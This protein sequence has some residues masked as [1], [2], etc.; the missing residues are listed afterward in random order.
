ML[1]RVSRATTDDLSLVALGRLVLPVGCLV[2][3]RRAIAANRKIEL[4]TVVIVSVRDECGDPF[5]R[6][7]D[8]PLMAV[9]DPHPQLTS[10]FVP[11]DPRRDAE[12]GFPQE[13]K[14][15]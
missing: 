5:W 13:R 15:R 10:P 6:R 14:A 1:G 11:C 8:N 9:P 12:V 3:D 4:T 2:G 7:R